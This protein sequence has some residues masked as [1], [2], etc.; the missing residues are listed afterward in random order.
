M[1]SKINTQVVEV[2]RIKIDYIEPGHERVQLLIEYYNAISAASTY[3]IY[4]KSK[5]SL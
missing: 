3:K 2:N 1:K 4:T 5:I